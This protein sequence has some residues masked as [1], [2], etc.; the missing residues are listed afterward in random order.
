MMNVEPDMKVAWHQT[1]EC[2][3]DLAEKRPNMKDELTKI[4]KIKRKLI[5]PKNQ[6]QLMMEILENP[7]IKINKEKIKNK[8]QRKTTWGRASVVEDLHLAIPR[9]QQVFSDML[10]NITLNDKTTGEASQWDALT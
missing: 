2:T 7:T 1:I 8:D 3:A 6:K 10:F 9:I 5:N 4:N